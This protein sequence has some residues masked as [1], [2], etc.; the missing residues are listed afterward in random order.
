MEHDE[1]GSHLIWRFIP[2]ALKAAKYFLR[3]PLLSSLGL[4]TGL[5][6]MAVACVSCRVVEGTVHPAGQSEGR[7]AVVALFGRSDNRREAPLAH[8][9]VV[10]LLELC[11]IRHGLRRLGR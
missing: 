6:L 2:G 4:G 9:V 5:Q 3:S 1:I 11:A 7:G 8:R 10:E